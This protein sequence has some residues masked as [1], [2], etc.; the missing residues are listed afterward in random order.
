MQEPISKDEKEYDLEYW[1]STLHNEPLNNP[2]FWFVASFFLGV[3]G[4]FSWEML[5]WYNGSRH[6][7]F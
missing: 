1:K 6:P 2:G 5:Q 3:W 7:K 4:G